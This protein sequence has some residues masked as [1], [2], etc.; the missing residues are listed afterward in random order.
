MRRV[1]A[2]TALLQGEKQ[3]WEEMPWGKSL[4]VCRRRPCRA[5][6]LTAVS[7]A[8]LGAAVMN[9]SAKPW[10]YLGLF[11][12]WSVWRTSLNPHRITAQWRDP[13][14]WR[15]ALG[16]STFIYRILL[17]A[18]PLTQIL[19]TFNVCFPE[20]SFLSSQEFLPIVLTQHPATREVVIHSSCNF[21]SEMYLWTKVSLGHCLSP[22]PFLSLQW[23]I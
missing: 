13:Q 21:P 10:W 18:P 23:S 16:N 19:P 4:R 1:C 9:T 6:S 15:R 14:G 2:G 8:S 22:N 5:D 12:E 3:I 7:T 11:W 20:G 17:L